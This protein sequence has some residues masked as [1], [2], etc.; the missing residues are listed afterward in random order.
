M[1]RDNES[2]AGGQRCEDAAPLGAGARGFCGTIVQVGRDR[3]DGAPTSEFDAELERRLLEI[4]FVE[5][6]TVEILH[7]G[8]IGK[9]PI[10]VRVD[11]MKVALR[12]REANAILVRGRAGGCE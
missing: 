3:V 10:V 9:D 5:G 6:A 12:R 8:F 1:L 7:E 11:D 4:G 2:M